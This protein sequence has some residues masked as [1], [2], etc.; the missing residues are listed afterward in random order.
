MTTYGL[1]AA[2]LIVPRQADFLEIIQG[3]FDA[4]LTALGFTQLP[5]YD[6]D[7][8]EGEIT[9]IMAQL[10]GQQSEYDQAVYDARSPGNATGIQLDSLALIAGVTRNA[11]TYG[12]A[13][14]TI[15]GTVGTIIVQ[16][17]LIEWGGDAGDARWALTDDITIPA[18]GTITSTWQAVEK[19]E[20]IATTGDTVTIVTPVSGW[21]SVSFAA[22]A[23]PGNELETDAALR[24]RRQ[25]SLQRSGARNSAALLAALLDLDFVT[26][27]VVLTNRTAASVTTDGITLDAYTVGCVVAPSTITTAQKAE[28]VAAIYD[29]L[30][31]TDGTGGTNSGTVTKSDGRVETIYYSL[32]ANSNVTVDFTLAM[33]SGYVAADVEDALEELVSDYF[34]TLSVG[35]TVYPSPLIALAMS[36]DGIANVN[37]LLLNGGASAVTHTAVQLPVLSTFSVA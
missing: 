13:T 2:G 26:G 36:L 37:A 18:S 6:H 3:E 33:E 17:K 9:E 20:I 23:T 29:S 32:A 5:D 25:Q 12:T 21:T 10:L 22:D 19:G 28:V 1:S 15:T 11:A 8:F 34:L 31:V 35:A 16:G 24:V 14:G 4:R 27:A 30:G 7:T